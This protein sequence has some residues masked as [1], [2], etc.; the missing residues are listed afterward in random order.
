MIFI[1][2][3]LLSRLERTKR[4]G[5]CFISSGFH[6]RSWSSYLY[7]SI[8]ELNLQIYK[9]ILISKY[10]THGYQKV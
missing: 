2:T 9:P 1:L 5:K 6:K 8:L 7:V 4:M 3:L 10:V